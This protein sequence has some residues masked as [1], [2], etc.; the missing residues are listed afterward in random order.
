MRQALHLNL[1]IDEP[2]FQNIFRLKFFSNKH[3]AYQFLLTRLEYYVA[4]ENRLS[5]LYRG[6]AG[7]VVIDYHKSTGLVLIVKWGKLAHRRLVQIAV[8]T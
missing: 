1:D 4:C 8:Q 5:Q 7:L 6:G 2:L 3:Y